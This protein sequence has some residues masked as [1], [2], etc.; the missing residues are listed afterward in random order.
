[1]NLEPQFQRRRAR[2]RPEADT[3]GPRGRLVTRVKKQ[4]PHAG[5]KSGATS[6][7]GVQ[8]RGAPA[9]TVGRRA[10]DP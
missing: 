8:E 3:L 2:G 7:S 10:Q 6:A 9:D 4:M 1:M 5:V